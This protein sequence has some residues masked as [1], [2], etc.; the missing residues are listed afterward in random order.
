MLAAVG[1]ALI[2]PAPAG[3]VLPGPN[4]EIVFT[5]GRNDGATIFD[6]NHAQ[7]WIAPKAGAAPVRVTANAAI[8]H[9]HASWSPDGTKLVYSAGIPPD[10]DIWIL[11]LTQ[12]IS[13]ANPKD[14]TQTPG[15]AEDRPSWSPDGT[16]VAYQSKNGMSAAQIIVQTVT[17]PPTITVL[18]QPANTGDAGKPVWS[19]DSHT[20]YYSLLVAPGNDDIY[21][22]AADDSGTAT[23]VVTG[24]G[25][26]Y[27]P[28][29]SPDGQ[30]LC[31]TRGAFGT[32]NATVQRSTIAGTNVTQIANSGLGDYNCA[33]SP[34]GTKIAYVQGI[35]GNGDLMVMNADGT[36]MPAALVPN[37]AGRFDGNPEWFR[38]AP[39]VCQS[40]SLA[41]GFDASVTIPLTCLDPPPER[42]PVTLSIVTPPAHGT[43]GAISQGAVT[44]TPASRFSGTDQ[45]TFKGNDG[46]SDSLVA[47]VHVTVAPDTPARIGSLKVSPSRWRL[48][49]RLVQISRTGAPVGT[50]IT[51]TLDKPARVTLAFARAA[52]GR[53]VA[54]RCIAVTRS[55]R[56]RPHCARYTPAG[57]LAF[58][59]HAGLNRIGF[60]GRLS[61]RQ[62][63]S[64]GSYRLTAG[65]TDAAGTRSLQRT[66]G[67]A[68]V[69]Q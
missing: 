2:A 18:T 65:A 45:F 43:L 59:A 4:G 1:A 60:E 44:Y 48:G 50:R 69:A 66:A 58:S 11:D 31:F 28:A 9:R 41:A 57:S 10:Y 16:R 12:P 35:F 6:D 34:D 22:K 46:T 23:P 19:L 61:R 55:N 54:H 52:A 68:I 51:F 25:D 53:V 29:V 13:A 27:Q 33:W 17:T 5:S 20:L 67:F 42:G 64:I 15:I 62:K 32:I 37:V 47:A 39:P 3:A 63:L 30:S 38:N 8:Q 21:K 36:G 14:I 24:P 49:S 56:S 40:R 26:D 7:L